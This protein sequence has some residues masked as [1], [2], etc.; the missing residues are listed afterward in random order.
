MYCASAMALNLR[1]AAAAGVK[2]L[3]ETVEAL[4]SPSTIQCE[5]LLVAIE[6]KMRSMQIAHDELVAQSAT[7]D[8]VKTHVEFAEQP[9]GKGDGA[10]D[11]QPGDQRRKKT[12][13]NF[14]SRPSNT[15]RHAEAAEPRL[16]RRAPSPAVEAMTTTSGER[17]SAAHAVSYPTGTS[18]RREG[19]SVL[20]RPRGQRIG[21]ISNHCG[22]GQ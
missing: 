4:E 18:N 9:A 19:I 2:R 14:P 10:Q 6:G 17:E 8:E 3:A 20:L 11:A 7:E 21:H 1:S 13:G 22:T 12:R 15:K 16:P 5:N